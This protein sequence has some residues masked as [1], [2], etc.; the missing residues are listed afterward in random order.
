[1]KAVLRTALALCLLLVP[2]LAGCAGPAKA[3]PTRTP[4]QT[5]LT[6]KP[7]YIAHRGGD[8]N[9][10]EASVLAYAAAADWNRG[11]A[12]EVPVWRTSDGVWVVSEQETT[13]RVYGKHYDISSTPWDTLSA[14]RSIKGN[15]PMSRL[16]NDVLDVYGSSRILFVDNKSDTDAAAFLN[17]L[18]SFAGRSQYVIKCY[19]AASVTAAEAHRRGYLTWGYYYAKD[20]PNFAATQGRFDLLGQEYTAP[21]SAFQTMKATGK[22]VIAHIIDSA[23]AAKT[24]FDKGADGLMVSDVRDVVPQS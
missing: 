10:P 22:P 13:D 15:Q 20:M 2:G 6:Q 11:M 12:L 1:M 24:A 3:A 16:V 7:L 5:W 4:L 8:A 19:W 21:A 9:W 18:D 23:A 17:L 14:L